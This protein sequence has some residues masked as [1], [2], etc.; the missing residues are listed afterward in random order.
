MVPL[1]LSPHKDFITVQGTIVG[2]MGTL[3][4][5]QEPNLISCIVS[6]IP[7]AITVLVCYMQLGRDYMDC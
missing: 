4:A 3:G 1:Q 2:D 6:P 5:K 7:A